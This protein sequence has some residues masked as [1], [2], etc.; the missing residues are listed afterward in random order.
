MCTCEVTQYICIYMYMHQTNNFSVISP[1]DLSI[2]RQYNDV[3]ATAVGG[4]IHQGLYVYMRV[5]ARSRVFYL[6]VGVY[7]Y[8]YVYSMLY[9]CG[10][11]AAIT[12]YWELIQINLL[13]LMLP[14]PS[15]CP[16]YFIYINLWMNIQT[17]YCIKNYTSEFLNVNYNKL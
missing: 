2:R 10:E 8:I 13:L 5:C 11:L 1:I 12:R 16:F 15:M 3:S 9:A 14:P 17:S 6:T 7:V 4:A